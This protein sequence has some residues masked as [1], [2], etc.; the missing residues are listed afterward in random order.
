MPPWPHAWALCSA[1]AAT[2]GHRHDDIFGVAS[3]PA[4]A[5]PELFVYP[6]APSARAIALELLETVRRRGTQVLD[7]SRGVELLQPA[8]RRAFNVGEARHAPQ[9]QD[10]QFCFRIDP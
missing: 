3:C 1:L 6:Q 5:D 2:D 10:G 9:R 8:P 4:K 7:V